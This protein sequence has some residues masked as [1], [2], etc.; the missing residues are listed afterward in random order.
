MALLIKF[1]QL[2]AARLGTIFTQPL[3]KTI[4][5]DQTPSYYIQRKR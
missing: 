4:S 2:M 1:Y 3:W 5:L